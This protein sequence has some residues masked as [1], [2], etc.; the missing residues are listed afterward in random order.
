MWSKDMTLK[1]GRD[2]VGQSTNLLL[3]DCGGTSVTSPEDT[4]SDNSLRCS[5]Y[6]GW[7]RHT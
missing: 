2:T 3:T 6:V 1:R 7:T 5:G 4:N